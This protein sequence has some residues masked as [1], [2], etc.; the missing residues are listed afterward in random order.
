MGAGPIGNQTSP[1]SS[2]QESCSPASHMPSPHKLIEKQSPAQ[3]V[4]FSPASHVPLPH[5]A[6][7]C[8]LIDSRDPWPQLSAS[9][10]TSAQRP[11]RAP[12]PTPPKFFMHCLRRPRATSRQTGEHASSSC[13]LSHPSTCYSR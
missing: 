5:T 12:I 1:Q 9:T 10:P 2:G 13:V 7:R 6:S 8:L 4:A 11:C 3:L